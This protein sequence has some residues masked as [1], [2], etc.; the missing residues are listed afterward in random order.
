METIT[1]ETAIYSFSELSSTAKETAC[2]E[3]LWDEWS[4]DIVSQCTSILEAMGFYSRHGSLA[5][6]FTGFW[7]QGDGACFTGQVSYEKGCLKKIKEEYPQWTELHEVVSRYA[8]VQKKAFYGISGRIEHSGMYYHEYSMD[9]YLEDRN[10]AYLND[11]LEKEFKEV[12]QDLAKLFYKA[13]EED[14]EYQISEEC[15]EDTAEANGYK[16]LENGKLYC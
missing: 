11:D 12:C 7:S 2:Q 4:A 15:A 13:I 9:Y 3:V 16:F 6:Y 8:K 5:V 10:G 14:Y 1:T